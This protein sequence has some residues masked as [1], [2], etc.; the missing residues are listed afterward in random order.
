MAE[1]TQIW[2]T[3][4][5]HR[6]TWMPPNEQQWGVFSFS[7]CLLKLY[8]SWLSLYLNYKKGFMD[9]KVRETV[10]L[11]NNILSCYCNC[12]TSCL[13]NILLLSAVTHMHEQ[14]LH[15]VLCDPPPDALPR[16]KPKGQR[17]EPCSL[18]SLALLPAA[19]PPAGVKALWVLKHVC[20][21]PKRVKTRL[22][23][24]LSECLM[25]EKASK[26]VRALKHW[27]I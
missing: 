20:T 24:R 2:V 10:L 16:P 26:S 13:N 4:R 1:D 15:L 19:T 5:F 8:L 6:D 25:S 14:K 11:P 12:I 17:S 3:F 21:P 9:S 22:D 23:H 7:N 27:C 18:A